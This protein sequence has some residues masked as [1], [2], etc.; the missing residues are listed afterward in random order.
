MKEKIKELENKYYGRMNDCTTGTF[1]KGPCGDEI[2][3][4]LDI[5]NKKITDVK[6]FTDGC[7]YTKVCGITMAGLAHNRTVFEAMDISA[8]DVLDNCPA[9]PDDHTHCNILAVSVLYKA[10]ALYLLEK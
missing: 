6:I 2:E 7:E 4:Y 8:K 1:L 10:I 5:E 9:I 3:L